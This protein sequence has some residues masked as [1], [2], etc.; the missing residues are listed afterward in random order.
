MNKTIIAAKTMALTYHA[1]HLRPNNTSE[2]CIVHLAEVASYVA[3]ATRDADTIAAAWLHDVLEDT[4]AS[5]N[6][7][8]HQVNNTTATLVDWLTDPPEWKALRLDIRKSRQAQRI[9]RAPE[10]AKL[11][12]LADQISN[13]RSVLF[14]PPIDWRLEKSQ[15][16]IQG[17]LTVG[18]ACSGVSLRLDGILDWYSSGI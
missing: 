12:K 8:Q 10:A 17:A 18:R 5:L 3:D 4:S 2:P 13:I 6:D 7:I 9:A 16:Y 14:D 11:V 15:Q 1:Q